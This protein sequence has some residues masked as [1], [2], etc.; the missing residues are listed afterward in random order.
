MIIHDQMR[1]ELYVST[2]L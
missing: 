1:H 2:L